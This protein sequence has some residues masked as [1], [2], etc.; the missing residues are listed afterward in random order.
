MLA[1]R[2]IVGGDGADRKMSADRAAAGAVLRYRGL[3]RRSRGRAQ[4]RR[5]GSFRRPCAPT[6]LPNASRRAPY[7]GSPASPRLSI[8]ARSIDHRAIQ[9]VGAE[10][11]GSRPIRQTPCKADVGH[12]TP[13]GRAECRCD[14]R[15]PGTAVS[16][17]SPAPATRLHPIRTI[18]HSNSVL[19]SGTAEM[20][21]KVT[22]AKLNAFP[23]AEVFASLE[24]NRLSV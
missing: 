22:E 17:R 5:D 3:R 23:P 14:E 19:G 16:L 24:S 15:S 2:W 7:L 4:M 21:S 12:D 20:T 6:H 13:S 8:L 18:P 10:R 1:E 11:N 9:A